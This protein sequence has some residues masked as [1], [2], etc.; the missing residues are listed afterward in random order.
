MEPA[1]IGMAV[2]VARRLWAGT[3]PSWC[4]GHLRGVRAEKG[5]GQTTEGGVF[6]LS[7]SLGDIETANQRRAGDL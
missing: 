4:T 1:P 7:V 2:A 5:G 6:K 3:V